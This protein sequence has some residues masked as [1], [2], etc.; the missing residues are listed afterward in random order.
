MNCLC[1]NTRRAARTLTRVYEDHLRPVNLTPAQF[2]LLSMLAQRPGLSQ[3]ELAEV[4]DLD[5]TTLSRSLKLMAANKW[6]AG[7][8][9][10]EDR[11]KTLYA[12]TAAGRK[13]HTAALPHW[14]RA[15]QKMR[16]Q[17]GADWEA[18]LALVKRLQRI[19]A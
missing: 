15:Q 14:E 13:V 1:L 8:Q 19:A 5:Q 11:R 18:A 10:A 16:K 17:L 7:K 2:G 3:M 9:G 4:V 6:I 12:L